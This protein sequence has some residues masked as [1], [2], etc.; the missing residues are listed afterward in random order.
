MCHIS[1]V[2]FI[3][4]NAKDVNIAGKQVLEVGSNDINGNVRKIIES[5]GPEK[6]TGT[7]IADG[8]TV[9]VVCDVCDLVDKFGENSFDVVVCTEVLEHVRDWRKAIHNIKNVCKPGG[10]VL[11]TTRSKGFHYHGYPYDFWRYDSDDIK[12]IFSDFDIKT[13]EKDNEAPGVFV[14][15]IKPVVFSETDVSG[16]EL[17][18]VVL[19]KKVDKISD[20][21]TKSLMFVLSTLKSRL[22]DKIFYFGKSQL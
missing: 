7:D 1:C 11:I 3:S 12:N 9:D 18:S 19:K 8:S 21:D 22:A 2:A 14:K 16:Y 6:Y 20:K 13:L 5:Y 4:I 17:Y 10:T 15:M